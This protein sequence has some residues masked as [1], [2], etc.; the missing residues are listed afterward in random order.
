MGDRCDMRIRVRRQDE[1]LWEQVAGEPKIGDW[2]DLDEEDDGKSP[3]LE[4]SIEEVNYGCWYDELAKA[5]DLGCVFEGRHEEG[6]AYDAEEF[7]GIGGRLF[8]YAVG[9]DGGPI[10]YLDEETLELTPDCKAHLREQFGGIRK[11]STA[12]DALAG[13]LGNEEDE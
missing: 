1:K 7:G 11:A 12:L 10:V 5:A 9:K 6:C 8:I 13:T 4:G 2:L 3:V